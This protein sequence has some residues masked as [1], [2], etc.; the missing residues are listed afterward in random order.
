MAPSFFVV[1]D[2][3]TVIEAPV[4]ARAITWLFVTTS[5]VDEMII[6]VPSSSSV[7]DFTSIDTTAGRTFFTSCGIDTLPLSVAAPGVAVP[8]STVTP[9]LLP[10]SVAAVTPAPTPAPMSAATTATRIQPRARRGPVELPLAGGPPPG[11]YGNAA[12]CGGGHGA[13]TTGCGAVAGGHGSGGA[14]GVTVPSGLTAQEAAGATGAT[15]VVGVASAGGATGVVGGD[16]VPAAAATGATGVVGGSPSG[17]SEG[18]PGPVSLNSSA[19][20]ILLE[21]TG[22]RRTTPAAVAAALHARSS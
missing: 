16:G 3:V 14:G 7:E 12:A 11:G 2:S 22:V 17:G 13:P 20:G 9:E 4:S 8:S 5:P 21:R 1:P 19:I 18:A 6:P 15:G 10:L